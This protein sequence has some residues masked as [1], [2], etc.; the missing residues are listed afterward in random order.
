M[1]LIFAVGALTAS[2]TITSSGLED[3]TFGLSVQDK[4]PPECDGMGLTNI[5]TAP[6]FF[7]MYW[8]TA[9]ND[10]I[11]GT[12]A[13]NTLVG[14]AGNDCLLGGGGNDTIWGDQW[15]FGGTGNDVC[16]GGPGADTYNNCETIIEP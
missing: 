14:G 12:A 1:L 4:A 5:V 10:L 2:N 7:G 3:E 16:L 6:T 9:G 11:L 8:G 15:F 13:G